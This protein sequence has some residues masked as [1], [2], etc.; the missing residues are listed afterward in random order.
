MA[1]AY[2]RNAMIHFLVVGA[3]A[4]LALLKVAEQQTP[5][6]RETL[7]AEAL[8][9]RD[10]LKFEFFF[11]EKALF[12][13]ELEH[14]LDVRAPVWPA[15]MAKG[16]SAIYALLWQLRPLLAPA[17]LRP[18]LESYLVVAETLDLLPNDA[19]TDHKSVLQTEIDTSK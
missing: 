13:V 4:E 5:A 18:F 8:H 16:G 17:T 11:Q 14:Y 2:Y 19:A 12:M 1:A 10:V 9:V 7:H 15:E 3:I 6:P